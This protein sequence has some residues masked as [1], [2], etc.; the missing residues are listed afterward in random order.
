MNFSILKLLIGVNENVF[1]PRSRSSWKAYLRLNIHHK[2]FVCKFIWIRYLRCLGIPFLSHYFCKF[3]SHRTQHKL[4]PWIRFFLFT[5]F[6][7]TFIYF[8]LLASLFD[9]LNNMIL[10]LLMSPSIETSFERQFFDGRSAARSIELAY[11]ALCS[12]HD[13]FHRWMSDMWSHMIL[14]RS[15]CAFIS[16]GDSRV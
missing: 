8:V 11:A 2:T 5:T 4:L 6:S 14:G 16:G 12:F 9:W 15:C 7:W 10:H 1:A 3:S 13:G